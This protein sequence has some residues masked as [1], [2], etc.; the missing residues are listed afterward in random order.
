MVVCRP[1]NVATTTAGIMTGLLLVENGRNILGEVDGYIEFCCYIGE[2]SAEIEEIHQKSFDDYGCD[3]GVWNY[4][5][6]E[7]L[8]EFLAQHILAGEDYGSFDW[9]TK[10]A[11]LNDKFYSN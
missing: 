8:G 6:A 5:V 2:I 3:P 9:K 10:F 1:A 4:E 11:E 7:P